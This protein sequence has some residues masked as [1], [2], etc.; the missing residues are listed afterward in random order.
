MDLQDGKRMFG[1]IKSKLGFGSK[2][3]D[4]YDNDYDDY[5]EYAEYGDDYEEG[6]DDY[7]SAGSSYDRYAPVTTRST[8]ESRS[9]G[10]D[11]SASRP[12]LVSIEDVRANT[13]IGSGGASSG[14]QRASSA[15]SPSA[16]SSSF[17]R[18]MVDSSLPPQMTPE[19]T[20]A[21]SAAASRRRSEG[22][23]SLFSPTDGASALDAAA[24]NT[25]TAKVA[26]AAAAAAATEASSQKS[27]YT[28]HRVLKVLR[29]VSYNEAEGVVKSLKAGEVV[30]LVLPKGASG[31]RKRMLD[32][33]FGAACALEANVE[34][35][36]DDVFVIARGNGITEV[37]RMNLRNQGVL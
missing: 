5:D 13:H 29:P 11:Y 34:C 17:G 8:G 6:Y 21:V 15:A 12:R 30:V 24:S 16:R 2:N 33:S 18:T 10:S 20:A 26:A 3:N 25:P 7:A 19:G 36:A 37:E 23:D 1:D 31:L 32:F 27:S 4:G 22:L 9:S 35:I 28:G 14:S